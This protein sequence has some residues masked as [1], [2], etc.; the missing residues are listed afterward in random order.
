MISC[1]ED[2]VLKNLT[3]HGNF[4]NSFGRAQHSLVSWEGDTSNVL[5]EGKKGYL[6]V[7]WKAMNLRKVKNEWTLCLLES[8]KVSQRR[9]LRLSSD[10]PTHNILCPAP[11]LHSSQI[12]LLQDWHHD[13]ANKICINAQKLGIGPSMPT[14]FSHQPWK[15]IFYINTTVSTLVRI[16]KVRFVQIQAFCW[17]GGQYP[18]PCSQCI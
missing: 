14:L 15:L 2:R 5:P 9:D 7:R 6:A 16:H 1:R 12:A 17:I 10:S 11:F 3:S 13:D 4:D 8:L 18:F